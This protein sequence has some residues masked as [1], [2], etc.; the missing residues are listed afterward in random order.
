MLFRVNSQSRRK[1]KHLAECCG[2]FVR[3]AVV[4]FNSK[5]IGN[6][7]E[8]LRILKILSRNVNLEKFA[9]RPLSCQV[10][11]PIR[12]AVDTKDMYLDALEQII[13][14]SKKLKHISLG[15]ISDL[16]D[17]A[18][19]WLPLLAAFQ[20]ESMEVL[21]LSSVKEDP[22]SY[23]LIDLP[24][25][26]LGNLSNLHTLGIDYDY[27]SVSLF[28]TLMQKGHAP[29]ERLI[30]HVHGVE[31]GHE[32]IP[33]HTWQRM[34][35]Q[36]P[37]LEVT[38]N[39]IHSI[40]GTLALLDILQPAMP[41]AHLRMFFCQH[42]NTAAIGF[43]SQHNCNTLQSIHIVDGFCLDYGPNQYVTATQE[44]PFVML[45]WRCHNLRHFT[46]TGYRIDT[47][48]VIAI[49]R[50]RG[51]Q[52]KTLD[53]PRCCLVSTEIEERGNMSW[54]ALDA[55]HQRCIDEVSKSIGWEWQ[56]IEE[57]E[58]HLA[59]V[60]PMADAEAAYLNLLLQDQTW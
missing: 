38:L 26:D 23:G 42:L 14:N 35:K 18:E 39:L 2:K 11:W 19:E 57:T 53:I 8:C 27:V 51:T 1:A 10:E 60:D 54:S 22:E 15:C 47:E 33:N 43:I 4:E 36:N 55:A 28:D 41:V 48:D 9:L 12:D 31:P 25:R 49:A 29:L 5:H 17:H 45:A 7:K 6:V 58:L 52:L 24:L 21:H 32:K 56:P 44:N 34:V 20:G 16:L 30:I 50:L 46:L 13:R 40:D 37:S 3:E 59:V